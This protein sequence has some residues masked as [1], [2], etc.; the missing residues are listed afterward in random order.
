MNKPLSRRIDWAHEEGAA[1]V[2]FALVVP[3]LLVLLLGMV[4]FGKAFNY[5]IDE[6]HLANEGARWAMVDKNPS[7]TGQT[8]Q[9]YIQQ[10]ATTTELRNGGTASIAQPLRICIAFPADDD[11]TT[12]QVGDPVRVTASVTYSWMPFLG[13]QLGLTQTTIT[14]K[15]TMRLEALPTNYAAGCTP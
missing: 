15:S 12:G 13:N 10:Q 4:D 8:L 7:T 3:I 2:E 11:G 6:T 5:W 9:Q 14:G 1:L